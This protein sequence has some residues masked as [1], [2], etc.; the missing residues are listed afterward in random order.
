LAA[1][2]ITFLSPE[3]ATPV[4]IHVSFSLSRITIPGL[5]LGLP[6]LLDLF[7]LIL[8]DAHTSVSCQ[9]LFVFLWICCNV[10]EH[11]LSYLFVVFRYWAY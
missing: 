1:L 11:T 3:I 5:L 8:V 2:F 10:V 9:I 6:C 4:S 7:L